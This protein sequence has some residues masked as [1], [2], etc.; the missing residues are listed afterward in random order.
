MLWADDESTLPN[1]SFSALVQLKSLERR[2]GKDPQLKKLTAKPSK[3][4]LKKR[5][6]VQVDKSECFRPDN[7]REWYLPHH[8]VIPPTNPAK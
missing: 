3:R 7:R 8:S 6:I 1:N 2:L 5:Y 4:I